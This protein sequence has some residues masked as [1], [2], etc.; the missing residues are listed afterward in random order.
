[1]IQDLINKEKFLDA[2][3]IIYELIAPADYS[4]IVR[5]ELETPRYGASTVHEVTLNLDPKIV[6]TT[7]FDKIYD[8]YCTSGTASDGYNVSKYYDDHLMAD[9]RS[10]VRIIIKAHGCVSDPNR[11]IL[12]KSQ[13]FK[14][15]KEYSN[16]YRI[17]DALFLSHTLLFIG[18]SLSDPDIQLVLENVNIT[19]PTPHPHYFVIESGI[20]PTL[21]KA[22][23][24]AYNL[25]FI[26]YPAGQYAELNGA[27]LELVND[28]QDHRLANPST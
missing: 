16:F 13:Y 4:R 10:S 9:L 22:N 8:T 23:K 5:A 1:M 21:L 11:M 20:N 28:V 19:A 17:L 15:R 27:L 24:N 3:E 18:Y 26:D 2:A 25:Q 14:A 7:N 6:I 12:T